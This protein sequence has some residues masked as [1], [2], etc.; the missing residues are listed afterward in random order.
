MTLSFDFNLYDLMRNKIQIQRRMITI[1]KN[2]ED[3]I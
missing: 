3:I 2:T 1:V